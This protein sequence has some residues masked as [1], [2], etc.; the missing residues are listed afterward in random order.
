MRENIVEA[1]LT[2]GE[3]AVV[4][5]SAKVL[6]RVKRLAEAAQGLAQVGFAAA[7]TP[8]ATRVQTAIVDTATD[9]VDHVTSACVPVAAGVCYIILHASGRIDGQL[10]ITDGATEALVVFLGVVGIATR[11]AG[12]IKSA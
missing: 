12:V 1:E 8:T 4:G 6:K 11:V 3:L 7:G 10:D 2:Q 9:T 5:M